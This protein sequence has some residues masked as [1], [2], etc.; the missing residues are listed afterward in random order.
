MVQ[1]LL[2]TGKVDVNSRDNTGMT[3]FTRAERRQ[4]EGIIRMLLKTGK[5]AFDTEPGFVLTAYD[6]S[7]FNGADY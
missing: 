7:V 2:G 3:P 5:I 4:K 1:L 6:K